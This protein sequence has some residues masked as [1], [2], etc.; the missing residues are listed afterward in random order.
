MD[1]ARVQHVRRFHNATA[2]STIV[3]TREYEAANASRA[4]WDA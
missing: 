1:P 4:A 2:P 3:S